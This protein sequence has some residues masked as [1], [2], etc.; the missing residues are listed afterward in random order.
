MKKDLFRIDNK[1]LVKAALCGEI[2]S[3]FLFA[4]SLILNMASCYSCDEVKIVLLLNGRERRE[5]DIARWLPHAWDDER[6]NNLIAFDKDG[7]KRILKHIKQNSKNQDKQYY[8]IFGFNMELTNLFRRDCGKIKGILFVSDNCHQ[9]KDLDFNLKT[10]SRSFC[11]MQDV[12]L[13]FL[14][15][16]NQEIEDVIVEVYLPAIERC[17]DI[18]IPKNKKIS[19]ITAVIEQE[20]VKQNVGYYMSEE[21]GVL[22]EREEGYILPTELTPDEMGILTGTRLMLI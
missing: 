2:E 13:E 9:Q 15:L 16:A 4:K 20:F 10:D 22:C 17:F 8:M 14:Q 5:L 18:R 19:D 6:N 12:D 21:G 1:R 11:N 7:T 3:V